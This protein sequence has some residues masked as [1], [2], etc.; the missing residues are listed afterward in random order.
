MPLANS[1]VSW[2]PASGSLATQER[3]GMRGVL[4]EAGSRRHLKCRLLVTSARETAIC[5]G[6][7]SAPVRSRA[8]TST[9]K[10]CWDVG[11]SEFK[12]RRRNEDFAPLIE[13]CALSLVPVTNWNVPPKVPEALSLASWSDACSDSTTWQRICGQCRRRVRGHDRRIVRVANVDGRGR[14]R[15]AGLVSRADDDVMKGL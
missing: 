11:S 14:T 6:A 10:L 1:A 5:C 9:R 13:N 2:S 7:E 15:G 3:N 8:W 4:V 12:F